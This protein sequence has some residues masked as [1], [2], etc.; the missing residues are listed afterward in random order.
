[1]KERKKQESERE[2]GGWVRERERERER[3]ADRQID[4]QTTPNNSKSEH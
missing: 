4:R 3:E 1:M 2:S